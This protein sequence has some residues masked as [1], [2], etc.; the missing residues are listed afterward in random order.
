[1]DEKE[2][3]KNQNYADGGGLNNCWCLMI[4]IIKEMW[5]MTTLGGN[6]QKILLLNKRVEAENQDS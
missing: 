6:S 3:T 5:M 4:I 2:G 1:M